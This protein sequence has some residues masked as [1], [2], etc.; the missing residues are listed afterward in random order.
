MGADGTWTITIDSNFGKR[1]IAFDLKTEGD[2][3]TG[4][5]VAADYDLNAEIFDGKADGDDL[6]W[7]VKVRK[8]VRL[9]LTFTVAVDGDAINGKAKAGVFGS[10]PVTGHRV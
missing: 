3:L 8:P 5:A 6:F 7:K 1:D 9:T 4:S 10:F 2:S